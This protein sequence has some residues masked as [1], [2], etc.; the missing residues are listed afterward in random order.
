MKTKTRFFLLLLIVSMGV[1][2]MYSQKVGTTSMQFLSVMPSARGTALG[3]AYGVWAKGPEAVFWNPAGVA[4][5]NGHEYSFSYVRWL[6]DARQYA[7]A[8]STSLGNIGCIGALFE[9]VDYGTFE[10]TVYGDQ[11][12][13]PGNPYPYMT[14]KTFQPYAYVAGITYAKS[15][16]D[17]FST[18]ISFKYAHEQLFN[19]SSV[20]AVTNLNNNEVQEVHTY[21]DAYLF[22]IGVHYKTGFHS[23]EVGAAVQNF[24]PDIKYAVDKNPAPLLFRVGI[25][26]DIIGA[27]ALFV[28]D[29]LQRLGIAFDLFQSNDYNQQQ[30]LG[31]EYEYDRMFSARVGYKF[32]YDNEGLTWGAGVSQKIAGQR[33]IID[34]S[35]GSLGNIIGSF[36]NAHRLSLGVEIL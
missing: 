23:V 8:Y 29:N 15:L 22:D 20:K 26:A 14:G 28:D 32:N 9:Y 1:S 27:N 7:L 12:Y 36:G 19:E 17:K 2:Y 13:Y 10:E 33:I 11:V 5:T 30:H 6:F 3:N 18:G 25:A 34:Y 31:I 35:F 16:T 21:G 4:L 24:G